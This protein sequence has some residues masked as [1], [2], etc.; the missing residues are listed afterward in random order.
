MSIDDK[1]FGWESQSE[2]Q[3][4]DL[5]TGRHELIRHFATYLN[6]SNSYQTILYFYG[7]GGNG[8][9]LLLKFLREKCCKQLELETWTELKAKPDTEL[10]NIINCIQEANDWNGAKPVPS[11]LL[12]FGHQP[13]EE[14]QPQDPFYGLLMLRRFLDV[15]ASDLGYKLKFPL[16]DFACIWYLHK[17]GKSSEE[18]KRLFPLNEIAAFVAPL[19]DAVAQNPLGSLGKAILDIFAKDLSKKLTLYLQQ[20]GLTAEQVDEISKKNLDIELINTLPRYFAQDLNVA[21]NG[22]NAPPRLVLFFD[23]H[24]AFWG[25]GRNVPEEKFFYQDEWLRRLLRALD[26]HSG[27]VVV[28]SGREFPR[29]DKAPKFPIAKEYLD[30]QLVEELTTSDAAIYLQK[31]GIKDATLAAALINYASVNEQRVHPFYLGLCADVVLAAA[32]RHVSMNAADFANVP[33]TANK[34]RE[35]VNRL[36]RYVDEEIRLAVHA[37]SACRAFNLSLYLELGQLLHFHATEASFRILT[38]FSFV[39]QDKQRGENWYRIHDLLRR[40]DY[41]SGNETTRNA[42][43]ILEQYYRARALVAE[44]IYH[45]NR[46]S[47]EPAVDEWVEVLNAALRESNYEQCRQLLVVR[48]E[49]LIES[50]FHLGKVSSGEGH[51]FGRL[52]RYDE[53]FQEY[54]EAIALFERNLSINPNCVS[55]YNQKAIALARLGDLHSRLSNYEQAKQCYN[56][57]LATSEQAF[58]SAPEDFYVH[59][60][61]AITKKR[62]GELLCKL[63]QYAEALQSYQQAIAAYDEALSLRGEDVDLLNNKGNALQSLGEVLFLL[64]LN[65]KA[66]QCYQQAIAISE[67]ALLLN[68]KSVYAYHNKGNALRGLGELHA[69]LFQTDEMLSSYKRAIAAFTS[70]LNLAP[71][72]VY[73]YNDKGRTLQSLGGWQVEAG[74]LELGLQ[75]YLQAIEAYNQALN[76]TPDFIYPRYRKGLTLKKLGELYCSESQKPEALRSLQAADIEFSRCLEIAPA[77]EEARQQKE[78]ITVFL[79]SLNNF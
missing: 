79:N 23:T 35:L 57:A 71:K 6:D 33:A 75:T 29:W 47:W 11:V 49:L 20:R 65:E 38:S 76:I 12:D 40:L 44:A 77:S 63:S 19:I 24:E 78:E 69:R 60:Y 18:I 59:K 5:F 16:Y 10:A 55:T 67:Q 37:L 22:T 72:Y 54:L 1:D 7:D 62:L 58:R 25:T 53:A 48:S 73:A 50:E 68:S 13:R 27:I 9:S 26:L 46:L 51:Y 17:K 45:A 14:N 39:W 64:D 42:H 30:R 56:Q 36:L 28:V 74:Q 15:A 41:S 32:N 61:S 31:A 2:K 8:K 3:K 66:L 4:L 21:M 43:A 52:A 70:A 34:S